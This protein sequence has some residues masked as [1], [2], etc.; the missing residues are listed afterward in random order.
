MNDEIDGATMRL[1]RWAAKNC[2]ESLEREAEIFLRFNEKEIDTVLIQRELF[3][4]L[5]ELFDSLRFFRE[6]IQAISWVGKF[7]D[8]LHLYD[9]I[10][11][12][13]IN[14][15]APAR[16]PQQ[17]HQAEKINEK[18]ISERSGN[19]INVERED[20]EFLQAMLK[21]RPEY[22]PWVHKVPKKL[23]LQF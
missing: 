1:A 22:L 8:V 15:D 23:F 13:R 7:S 2:P 11:A 4:I 18:I 17:A 21:R 19:V 9:M 20:M 6:N 3:E 12:I 16:P 5:F 14:E 10:Y